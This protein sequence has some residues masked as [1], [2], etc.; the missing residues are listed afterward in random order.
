MDA[1]DIYDETAELKGRTPT[2]DIAARL[3]LAL[4]QGGGPSS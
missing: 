1:I 4:S 2:Y 3:A